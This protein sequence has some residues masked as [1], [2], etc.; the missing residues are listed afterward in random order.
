MSVPTMV[1]EGKG[2]YQSHRGS[3]EIQDQGWP[4]SIVPGTLP[5][6]IS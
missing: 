3:R 4:S 2:T 6:G 5:G 1:D